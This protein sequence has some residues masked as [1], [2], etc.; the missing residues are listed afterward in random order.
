MKPSSLPVGS[1]WGEHAL[2][3]RDQ[4]LVPVL[5]GDLDCLRSHAIQLP[6]VTRL[7]PRVCPA[8]RPVLVRAERSAW[9]PCPVVP[10]GLQHS[11][12]RR[13][14]G[15]IRRQLLRRRPGVPSLQTGGHIPGLRRGQPPILPARRPN[16]ASG[17]QRA[18]DRFSSQLATVELTAAHERVQASRGGEALLP[19][20]CC[21]Y[22]SVVS[23]T[24]DASSW[25][26][27]GRAKGLQEPG[28]AHLT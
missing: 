9:R 2:T 12:L 7:R 22:S 13:S 25:H 11:P 6:L 4:L 18:S 21:S 23:K 15:S 27:R 26:C 1:A 24:R 20:R 10:A 17:G 3:P 28:H 16:S 14:P 5:L 8:V 19:L